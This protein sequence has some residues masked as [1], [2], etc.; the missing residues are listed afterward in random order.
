VFSQ[1]NIS[2]F[3]RKLRNDP[4]FGVY[5]HRFYFKH[6]KADAVEIRDWLEDRYLRWEGHQYRIIFYAS[7]DGG[8]YAHCVY[9]QSISDT[10]LIYA[11][12]RWNLSD[13]SVQ[14]GDR[15]KSASKRPSSNR[16]TQMTL[17][18]FTAAEAQI[19]RVRLIREAQSAGW[20]APRLRAKQAWVTMRTIGW[21]AESSQMTGA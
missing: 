13:L 17:P 7:V 11:K 2:R 16:V 5:K 12:L 4:F 21:S 3:R 9:M 1:S 15:I 8:Q 10:D 19:E 14:R 18:Q 20:S 6:D